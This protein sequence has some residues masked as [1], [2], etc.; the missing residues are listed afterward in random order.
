MNYHENV[1]RKA[2]TSMKALIS[3][4]PDISGHWEP[5]AWHIHMHAW[6]EASWSMPSKNV[7]CMS[8][9]GLPIRRGGFRHIHMHGRIPSLFTCTKSNFAFLPGPVCSRL[10]GLSNM[11]FSPQLTL[12]LLLSSSGFHGGGISGCESLLFLS[13]AS[14]SAG[15]VLCLGISTSYPIAMSE[16][17]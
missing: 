1:F 9:P 14:I 13:S 3:K 7:A 8:V 15:S 5:L 12:L 11:S 4:E 16:Q 10:S 17:P 2:K 6:L